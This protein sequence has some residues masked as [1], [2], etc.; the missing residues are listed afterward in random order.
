[1]IGIARHQAIPARRDRRCGPAVV[2]N[3]RNEG[4]GE[5]GGGNRRDDPGAPGGDGTRLSGNHIALTRTH[6]RFAIVGPT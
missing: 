1:M 6:D 3:H 4:R 5:R 2:V